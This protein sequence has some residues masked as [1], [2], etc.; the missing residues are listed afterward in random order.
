N[1]AG[2]HQPRPAPG[3][4]PGSDRPGRPVASRG[5]PADRHQRA[6]IETAPQGDEANQ[7]PRRC[8]MPGPVPGAVCVGVLGAEEMN[9]GRNG[10][11]VSYRSDAK[12]SY[13]EDVWDAL[14][15]DDV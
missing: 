6:G 2:R 13:R 10:E 8:A 1:E 4:H 3:I 14:A 12:A 9:D 15:S 5:G 7:R 11:T